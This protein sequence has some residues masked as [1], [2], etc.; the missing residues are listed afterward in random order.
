MSDDTMARVRALSDRIEQRTGYRAYH[1]TSAPTPT[2]LRYV[3]GDEV[4]HTPGKAYAKILGIREAIEAGRWDHWNCRRC[5][6]S[7]FPTEAE[8]D[9]HEASHRPQRDAPFFDGSVT[10][11][12]GRRL[13][14]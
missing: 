6:E 2:S 5:G 14:Q 7:L 10:G 8:R 3:F 9:E 11:L 13:S 4:V 12:D 1:Y